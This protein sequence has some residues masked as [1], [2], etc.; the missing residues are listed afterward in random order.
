MMGQ[1]SGIGAQ[2]WWLLGAAILAIFEIFAPGVFLIWM[3]AAMALTG[4]TVALVPLPLAVQL[5]LFAMLAIAAVYGGR[6]HYSRNPVSSADPLLND[7]AA[8]LIGETL[9]VVT[10]IEGGEGRVKVGDGVWTARG[11]DVTAG[12]RVVVTG[13]EG[14]CLNVRIAPQQPRL[15]DGEAGAA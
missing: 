9:T 13:V 2:W 14:T 12:T 1:L 11:P 7:R 3:A 10:A 6:R 5:A 4:I 8:R 15:P